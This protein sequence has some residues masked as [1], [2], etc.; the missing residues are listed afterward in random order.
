[1]DKK[2]HIKVSEKNCP[3]YEPPGHSDTY[4]RRLAGPFN[5]SNNIEFIIGEM[6]KTGDAAPHTHHG[7]DQMM[8]LL[9]GSLKITS[10]AT[11]KV[12]VFEP[13]DLVIF[14]DGVEHKVE[15]VSEHARF[16]VLYGPPKQHMGKDGNWIT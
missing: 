8:Y 11:G 14:P 10:P 1:M 3:V 2:E 7:F 13:G 16:V 15:V 12:D 9:E 5:G 6:G 4:N